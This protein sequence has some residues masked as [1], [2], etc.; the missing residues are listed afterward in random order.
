MYLLYT[1]HFA[2]HRTSFAFTLISN[3]DHQILVH[4]NVYSWDIE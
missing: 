2:R 4:I 1:D 3:R